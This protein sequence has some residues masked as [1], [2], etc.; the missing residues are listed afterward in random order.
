M[1]LLITDTVWREDGADGCSC[2]DGRGDGVLCVLEHECVEGF[3][4]LKLARPVGQFG[5]ASAHLG[6]ER[7]EFSCGGPDLA[8]R[9]KAVVAGLRLDVT[10]DGFNI[11]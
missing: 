5:C 2:Y 10:H 1:D 8:A 4:N 11:I 3:D 6:G 7:A 9:G